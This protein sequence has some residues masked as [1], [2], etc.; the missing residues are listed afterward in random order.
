MLEFFLKKAAHLSLHHPKRVLVSFL[1]ALLLAFLV[2]G[3][4]R[5][6]TDWWRLLPTEQGALKVFVEDLKEFGHQ[7]PL[8]ILLEGKQTAGLVEVAQ[9]LRRSLA[10]M[11]IGGEKAFKRV[12]WGIK[13]DVQG[14][15][16]LL[17]LYLPHP[18][19]YVQEEMVQEFKGKLF[20]EEIRMQVRKAKSLLASYLSPVWRELVLNDP[21]A[22]RNF[23][24]KRWRQRSPWAPS[25]T[26]GYLLSPDGKALLLMA[27]PS[28]PAADWGPSR[29]LVQRLEELKRAFPKV[30]ISFVGPHIMAVGKAG[31]LR[32][33]LMTSLLGCLAIVLAIFYLSYR[34]WA[35]L[36]FVGLPLL[37]GVQLTMGV[38]SLF[39]GGLN[40]ITVSFAAIIVG[41][42]I[43]FAI[44]IYHRYHH[45]RA[46]GR[47][48]S[49]AIEIT[50][51]KTGK[52]VWTGGLTTIAAFL[53]LGL[54]RIHGIVELGILVA[55]GLFFCLLA[56]SLVLP[57]FLIW[58]ESRGYR[59][60]RLGEWG[61]DRLTSFQR[62]HHRKIL[63]ILISLAIFGGYIGTKVKMMGG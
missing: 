25:L 9:S 3:R 2:T 10:E 41:L 38:A 12:R 17:S 53:T 61:L 51:T 13:A 37:V 40:L 24:F 4:L 8:Y 36:L 21:L 47:G 46:A 18:Q 28:F 30:E 22:L 50:L 6:E 19:L 23:L 35:T 62:A 42:G 26:E 27:E 54:A 11:K 49:E 29:E 56:T 31:I 55:T 20:E 1:L 15:Q 34:R 43:D 14:W 58:V 16:Q 52:G 44:H 33:D 5:F 63:I 48:V 57:S 45:E 32:Q 7:Q 60:T 39:T 59:Y